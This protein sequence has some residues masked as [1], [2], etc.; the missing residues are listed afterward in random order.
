[1]NEPAD[2]DATTNAERSH[3]EEIKRMDDVFF[4]SS[5]AGAARQ[6]AWQAVRRMLVAGNGGGAIATL[7]FMGTI[8]GSSVDSKAPRESLLLLALF[9]AGLIVCG[10][11]AYARAFKA[12]AFTE[13]ATRRAQGETLYEKSGPSQEAANHMANASYAIL[14]AARWWRFEEVATAISAAI[15]AAGIVSGMVM[16]WG[17]TRWFLFG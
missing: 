6:D 16:L 17:H 12:S 11:S 1:M 5:T 8:I 4:A 3:W 14:R 15:L 9:V 7:G 13:Y 2:P 10:I